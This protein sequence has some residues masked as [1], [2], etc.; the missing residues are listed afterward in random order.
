MNEMKKG[1]I[2]NEDGDH[3]Y[4]LRFNDMA[5]HITADE[6]RDYIDGMADTDVTDFFCNV[7][8][9]LSSFPSKVKTS[10]A[11]KFLLTEEAGK[12]C[13]WHGTTLEVA[14]NIWYKNHLDQFQIWCD[15]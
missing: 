9:L 15:R 5:E 14:Y 13:D 7:G 2:F 3:Y 1:I 11:D 8:Q 4:A 6:L 10:Y 12:P